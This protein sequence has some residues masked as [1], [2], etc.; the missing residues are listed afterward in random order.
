MQTIVQKG[1]PA[2]KVIAKAIPKNEITGAKMSNIIERMR[3]ALEACPDGVALAA[4]QIGEALRLFIVHPRVWKEGSLSKD[5]PLTYINPVLIRQSKKKEAMDEG[6]LS[7]RGVYGK[8]RRSTRATVEAYDEHGRKFTR[9]A[10][11]IL[12]QIFQHEIDHLDGTLFIDHA[13]DLVLREQET[14]ANIKNQNVK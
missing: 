6:C 13:T 14:S 5:E 9:G 7:V 11:G 3:E 1:H 2:L 8:T 4:P 12:A 10:G